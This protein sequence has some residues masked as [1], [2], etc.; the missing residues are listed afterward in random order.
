MCKGPAPGFIPRIGDVIDERR[1]AQ[2]QELRSEHLVNRLNGEGMPF[3][4]TVNPYRG[5]EMGCRYC[6][7]RPTHEYLGHTDP[8]EFEDRIYVKRADSFRLHGELKRARESGRE[9]A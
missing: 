6:Y 2:F 3:G 7:A 1:G 5:C 8:A 4:W 9:I